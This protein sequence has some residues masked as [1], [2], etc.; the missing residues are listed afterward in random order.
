MAVQAGHCLY[1][2][3]HGNCR[4]N[5]RRKNSSCTKFAWYST[6]AFYKDE[7]DTQIE[8]LQLSPTN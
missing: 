3:T 6:E 5:G 8:G 7:A 4:E 1:D 2:Y